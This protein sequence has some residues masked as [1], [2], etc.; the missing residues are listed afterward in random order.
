VI[1]AV[2]EHGFVDVDDHRGRFGAR[3]RQQGIELHAG[4]VPA[5]IT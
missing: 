1:G 5:L 4:D 2:V 3:L